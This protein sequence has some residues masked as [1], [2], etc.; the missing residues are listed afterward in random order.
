LI[1]PKRSART[2]STGRA[3]KI[4][5]LMIASGAAFRKVSMPLT[6]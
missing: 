4:I 2:A 1:R 6:L 5:S 3:V